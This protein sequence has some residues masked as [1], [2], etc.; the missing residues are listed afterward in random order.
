MD[1]PANTVDN[2]VSKLDGMVD[3][4]MKKSGIPGMAVAVVHGGK[5]GYAKGFGVK[6]VRSGDKIDPDTGVQLA[7]VAKPGSAT[8][9]AH[10]VGVNAIVWGTPIV[11]NLPWVA[12]ACSPVS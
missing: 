8:V 1:L 5:T 4:L 11:S 10:H 2:A 3:E 6:D 7:S 9:G 12:A